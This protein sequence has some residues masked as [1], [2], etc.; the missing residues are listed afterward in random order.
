[1]PCCVEKLKPLPPLYYSW[2]ASWMCYPKDNLKCDH[3]CVKAEPTKKKNFERINKEAIA[4][5]R[6]K[7]LTKKRT[8]AS[9]KQ[10]SMKSNSI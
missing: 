3:E 10:N 6:K 1:M 8:E 2:S 5:F 9:R 4:S 7:F